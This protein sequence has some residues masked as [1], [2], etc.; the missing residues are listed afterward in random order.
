MNHTLGDSLSFELNL[1]REYMRSTA[2]LHS[3]VYDKIT[4][5]L[6]F[7]K[8]VCV[9]D[10]S[11]QVINRVLDIIEQ[12]SQSSVPMGPTGIAKATGINKSTVHRLLATLHERSYVEKNEKSG[13]YFIG[14]MLIELVSCYIGN[15]E[16]QTEARPYLSALSMD[17]NLTAHLGILDGN[18]V[19]YIE[20]LVW[21]QPN[22]LYS[23]I[24]YRVPA[25]CSSLGKCLLACLSGEELEKTLSA[26]KFE[27]HTE[28]TITSLEMFKKQLRQVR[29]QGWAIDNQE[30]IVG[31]S[32]VGAPI[33]D[34]R[35]DII[36][37]ISAS[38]ASAVITPEYLPVV[39]QEV[40][41]T[42]SQ[43]SKRMGYLG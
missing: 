20:K 3:C 18:D 24:G 15:L 16:L 23:Q 39:V 37:A 41:S 35:G 4:V 12:L 19:I 32:C 1:A 33:Y 14:P 40:K 10:N 2:L 43:I 22:K 38:G 30:Y 26:C 28:N 29:D 6:Y 11:V 25:Y 42:A 36:A 5:S 21:F 34:Y 31:H 9:M 7:G 27:K 13:T 8:L 17:L